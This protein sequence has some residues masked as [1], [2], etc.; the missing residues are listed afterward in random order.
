MKATTFRKRFPNAGTNDNC[1]INVACPKCGSRGPFCVEIRTCV[2]MEDM[3]TGDHGD[4]EPT[5]RY[6]ECKGCGHT[7]RDSAFYIPGLDQA[8]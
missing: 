7:G 1:L 8:E 6:T 5:G 4:T 3:G 2:D